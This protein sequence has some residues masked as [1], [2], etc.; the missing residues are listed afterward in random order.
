LGNVGERMSDEE[1]R[2]LQDIFVVIADLAID[3]YLFKKS[4]N[5]SSKEIDFIN[6]TYR[7]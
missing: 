3:T 2:S 1:I 4:A 7:Q 6:K 5:K